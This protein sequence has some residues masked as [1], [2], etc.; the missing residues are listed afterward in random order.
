[1]GYIIGSKGGKKLTVGREYD[2][3]AGQD[4]PRLSIIEAERETKLLIGREEK[5]GEQQ[6]KE[7]GGS[8]FPSVENRSR[9]GGNQRSQR[10]QESNG[11]QAHSTRIV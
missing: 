5:R 7:N 11:A 6:Y 4:L 1:M 3:W 9:G 8:M 2:G 10:E